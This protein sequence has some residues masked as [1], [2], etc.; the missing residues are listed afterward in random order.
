VFDIWEKTHH[1][2]RKKKKKNASVAKTL[3]FWWEKNSLSDRLSSE[4]VR[5]MR[6][7]RGVG[8]REDGND[9]SREQMG[10]FLLD[11][12]FYVAFCCGIKRSR[13]RNRS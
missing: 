1:L 5:D 3:L 7:H 2:V 12:T 6:Q 4:P 13:E 8:E 9:R 11:M 10:F